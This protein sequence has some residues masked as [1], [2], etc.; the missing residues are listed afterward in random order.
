MK[1]AAQDQYIALSKLYVLAE[2]L[3]D[4]TT[5]STVLDALAAHAKE[6]DFRVL[7]D[8]E[9]VYVIYNSTVDGNEGRNWLVDLYTDHGE[10]HTLG[11]NDSAYPADFIADVARSLLTNRTKPGVHEAVQDQLTKTEAKLKK[12]TSELAEMKKTLSAKEKTNQKLQEK[13]DNC[14]EDLQDAESEVKEL[15]VQI[16]RKVVVRA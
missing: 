11:S 15:Q 2:Q 9:T 10:A 14:V 16:K 6:T 1:K 8:G 12:V 13:Y 5:K 7:P 4:E 3:V